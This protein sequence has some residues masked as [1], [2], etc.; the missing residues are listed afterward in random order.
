MLAVEKQ[1]HNKTTDLRINW[2]IA[3]QIM[4]QCENVV[5]FGTEFFLSLYVDFFCHCM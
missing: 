1:K 2:Y 3:T 5:F 4:I